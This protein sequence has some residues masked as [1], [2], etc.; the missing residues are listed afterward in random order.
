M[1]FKKLEIINIDHIKY[2]ENKLLNNQ[3]ESLEKIIENLNKKNFKHP[4][5][6][7]LYANSKALKK[8]SNLED[9]KIAF[10]I[11]IEIYKSNPSFIN[12]LYNACAI[13]FQID[14]YNEILMLLNRQNKIKIGL[15]IVKNLFFLSEKLE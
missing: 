9:K 4:A 2:L 7:L 3:F 15:D 6:Q 13:C 1:N 10:D 11:F 14:E 5:I 12:A 8:N